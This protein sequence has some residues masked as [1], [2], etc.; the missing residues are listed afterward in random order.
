MLIPTFVIFLSEV[1]SSLFESFSILFHPCFFIEDDALL[2]WGFAECLLVR[3][4][5][6]KCVRCVSAQAECSYQIQRPASVDVS[7]RTFR[8]PGCNAFHT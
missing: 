5:Q 3:Q 4:L 1:P 6:N 7:H 2:S 8:E